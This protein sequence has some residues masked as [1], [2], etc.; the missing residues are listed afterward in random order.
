MFKF[1]RTGLGALLLIS[2][3][4]AGVAVAGLPASEEEFLKRH[5][6]E[7]K[8]AESALQLWFEGVYLYMQGGDQ[9]TLGEKILLTMTKG[10]TDEWK[11]KA[12][13]SR[14]AERLKT[15]Q[16]I[17]RSYAKGSSPANGYSMDPS[18]FELDMVKSVQDG[19]NWVIS[20]QS[21][22]ADSPRKVTLTK[23]DTGLWKV[24]KFDSVYVGIRP[25]EK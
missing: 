9:A 22:G 16:H 18:S 11:T 21:S 15:E 4:W 14:F 10:M 6:S 25:S 5:A 17:F 19:D 2:F 13:F 8:N 24:V 20:L 23:D 12:G 7:A 3:L 1:I